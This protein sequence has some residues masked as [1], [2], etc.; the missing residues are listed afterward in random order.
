M[1]KIIET[2]LEEL[3]KCRIST[4]EKAVPTSNALLINGQSLTE[5]R[6]EMDAKYDEYR[7]ALLTSVNSLQAPDFVKMSKMLEKCNDNI[8][9]LE[10][11]CAIGKT[12]F[13]RMV[14]DDY[15]QL[16]RKSAALIEDVK[17]YMLSH[18]VAPSNSPEEPQPQMQQEAIQE[19]EIEEETPVEEE[20]KVPRRSFN[21]KKTSHPGE[22][23]GFKEME[24][25][26]GISH[27][28][29]CK[30]SKDP[31]LQPAFRYVGRAVRVDIAKLHELQRK[32]TAEKKKP[33]GNNPRKH[34]KTPTL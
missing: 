8:R 28:T 34:K 22:Y 9:N 6:V 24:K 20:V 7:I 5:Y 16:V 26:E 15:Q 1:D 30:I 27:S 18:P 14:L 2:Y 21:D 29:A 3:T 25:G 12:P 4:D 13:L 17:L 23:W 10:V 33:I 31:D 32:K 11:G 19:K